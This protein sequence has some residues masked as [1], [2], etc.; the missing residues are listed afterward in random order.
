[1]FEDT[2]EAGAAVG[3]ADGVEIYDGIDAVVGELGEGEAEDPVFWRGCFGC[4][5]LFGFLYGLCVAFGKE[6]SIG[7][8]DGDAN[9]FFEMVLFPVVG[10]AGEIHFFGQ[11]VEGGE[12]NGFI[13]IV[14][15]PLFVIIFGET[16]GVGAGDEVVLGSTGVDDGGEDLVD[17]FFGGW[18]GLSAAPEGRCD[19]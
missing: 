9:G 7:L 11:L 5:G 15:G 10:I 12:G 17:E 6:D 4:F 14:F 1:V 18:Q 16:T 3:A 8:G 2:G 13:E 19:G